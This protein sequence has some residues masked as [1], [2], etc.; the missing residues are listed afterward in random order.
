LSTIVYKTVYCLILLVEIEIREY[1]GGDAGQVIDVFRD[2][3]NTLR[4]SRG[5]NHPDET[6]DRV[7]GQPDNATLKMLISGR[8]L[9]VARVKGTGEI[10]GI[11]AISDTRADRILGSRYSRTHYVREKFQ[12]GRAGV[13][14]GKLLRLATIEE[15]RKLGARKMYGYATIESIGFHK[16]FGA[17]FVSMFNSSYLD[18][19]RSYYY[20]I[21]LRPSFWNRIPFE[22]F[23]FQFSKLV[24]KLTRKN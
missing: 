24:G 21:E 20:E 18:G 6:V 19:V 14:V 10:A 3:F 16:K 12:R 13:S 23:V 9:L 2:S 5:G 8:K 17:K 11:G 1:R 22:P 4:K 7:V 15:A